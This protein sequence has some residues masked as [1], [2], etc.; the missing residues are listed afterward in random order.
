MKQKSLL[1]S[2]WIPIALIAFLALAPMTTR[3]Q[4]SLPYTQGFENT[5]VNSIPD[6]W[7]VSGSSGN[8]FVAES[9]FGFAPH[10]GS[11][12]L[13]GIGYMVLPQFTQEISNLQLD[14]WLRS[15]EV[16]SGVYANIGYVTD[17][18]N[19][20]GTF[21]SVQHISG[22]S[23]YTWKR[24][25]FYGAPSGAR[26]AIY[27]DTD[28]LFNL[29]CFDDFRVIQQPTKTLPYFEGFESTTIG[30]L[31]DGWLA[32]NY[33]VGETIFNVDP[34]SGTRQ[35]Y[36]TDYVVLP[37]MA[38]ATS[39]LQLDLH[40]RA[41]G[42]ESGVEAEIGY[43]T[44]PNNPSGTF[45]SVRHVTGCSSYSWVRTTFIGAPAGARI[46]IY[47]KIS[48]NPINCWCLDAI[49]VRQLTP[50]AL[51]YEEDFDSTTTGELPTGWL[52]SGN[53]RVYPPY[54]NI[55]PHS[56]YRHL[57]CYGGEYM[58]LP[59]MASNDDLQ[60]DFYLRPAGGEEE[61]YVKIGYVTNPRSPGNNFHEILTINNASDWNA[62]RYQ[63]VH[64][65]TIPSN[66][67]LAIHFYVEG[68]NWWCVDDV[69]VYHPTTPPYLQ[70]FT[71]TFITA[72]WSRCEGTPT[73]NNFVA[74]ASPTPI[75]GGWKW[76]QGNAVF[77]YHAYVDIGQTNKNYWLITPSFYLDDDY[78]LSFNYALTKCSG[79]HIP[80]T[81]GAQ[82]D[83]MFAVFITTNNGDSW[84][85]LCLWDNNNSLF[86]SFDAISNTGDVI[87]FNLSGYTGEMVKFAFYAESG[88]GDA[89]N[90]LHVDNFN[91]V[92]YDPSTPPT[93][94]MGEITG[95]TAK[96]TWTPA[97]DWQ[98]G[99]DVYYDVSGSSL[100]DPNNLPSFFNLEWLN[101]SGRFFH[102]SN[103]TEYTI[104]NLEAYAGYRVWVRHRNANETSDWSQAVYFETASLCVPP[105]NPQV[106]TTQ[107]TATITWEP[108]QANQTSWELYVEGYDMGVELDEPYFAMEDL[109]PGSEFYAQIYGYCTDGDG[110]SDPLIVEFSTDDYD[111]LTVNEGTEYDEFV[112][113]IG[114]ECGEN[115]IYGNSRSQFIIPAEMLT[116]MQYSTIQKISFYS[117]QSGQPWGSGAS[118]QV[119]M[120]E[121]DFFDFDAEGLCGDHFYPWGNY[122]SEFYNG[123]LRIAN[124]KMTIEAASGYGF[125]YTNGNLLIGI[126]QNWVGNNCQV[127]WYGVGTSPIKSAMYEPSGYDPQCVQFLPKTT[128][129]YELDPYKPP[130]DFFAYPTGS[131]EVYFGWTPLEG[132]ASYDIEVSWSPDFDEQ[133]DQLLTNLT[134]TDY[135]WVDYEYLYPSSTYFAHIRSHYVVD[136]TDHVSSW[137]ESFEFETL[138]DCP[139]PTEVTATEIG[140]LTVEL[141][142]T[143]N[144]DATQWVI[145]FKADGEIG[146]RCL[147]AYDHPYAL[148]APYLEPGTT[149]TAR[150]HP[151]CPNGG[152]VFSDPITFT[153]SNNI[154]FADQNVKAL[155]VAN[156][157]TN[158]DNEL[159]YTEAAAVTSLGTVFQGNTNITS[160]NELQYFTGL[161]SINSDAF[162]LCTGLETVTLP[163]TL[164][165]IKSNA[166]RKCNALASI[167]FP[168][169]LTTIGTTAFYECTSLTSIFI[170]ASVTTI[171]ANPFMKNNLEFIFVDPANAVFDSRDNC[172]AIMKKSN[173]QLVV[174][175]KNT[176]IPSTAL[177]IWDHAFRECEGLT[178]IYIPENIHY[179]Y[180]NAF[181]GCTALTSVNIPS[182]VVKIYYCSF[183]DCS[184]LTSI[185]LPSG[186]T[187]IQTL[188]FYGC[189]SLSE[190]TLLSTNP[191]TVGENAF[192]YVD[193]T[194]PVY[195]PCERVGAYH[196]AAG[197]SEFS[198][199]IDPCV[200]NFTDTNVKALC[201]ANWDTSGDGE[202]SYDE[203]A[204]VTDLGTVFQGNTNITSFDELQ[205][206][207][208][209][210]EIGS[211]AFSYCHNLASITLPNSIQ[212][213]NNYAFMYC[214]RLTSVTL[215]EGLQAIYTQVFDYCVRL[216]SITIPASVTSIQNSAFSHCIALENIVVELGN[217]VFD[218]RDG[219]N[220][221]IRT[222]FNQLIIGCKN[223]IIPNTVTSIGW[224]AFRGHSGLT[225]IVLPNSITAIG[226]YAFYD[227][228]GLTNITLPASLESLGMTVFYNSGLTSMTVECETPP[229]IETGSSHSFNGVP[230][231]IPVYVY[232]DYMTDYYDINGTGTWGGF[233]NF[234]AIDC[235]QQ[236][237]VIALHEGWNWWAP[238]GHM[239]LA[240]L[241]DILD[242]NRGLIVLSQDAGFARYEED[243]WQGTLNEFVP[244]KMYKIKANEDCT[245]VVT[246]A[247]VTSV[248][249]VIKEGFNWFGYTGTDGLT[250][251]E[252]LG[253]FV[254]ADGDE[255]HD[256]DGI[257][258][259]SYDGENWSGDLTTLVRG[260][261]YL[262]V[263][264]DSEDK[265]LT[266]E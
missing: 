102:V 256:E 176:V 45:T 58:V 126:K 118:F 152:F 5:A 107:T 103:A 187:E 34:Y 202:L 101:N 95:H 162:Q 229:A 63:S 94:A 174:G 1:K 142:W 33:Y 230:R 117:G 88:T 242:Q 36:G 14:L 27:C 172:N 80:V 97:Y 68:F 85:P 19:P 50:L 193:K 86:P 129:A 51:P 39:T 93:V 183:Q 259:V 233:T 181:C 96:V 200:I 209:L 266:F 127:A 236:S 31:P 214:I 205:Y 130:T 9:V 28:D 203:A 100:P 35:L 155:C 195:V 246:V 239:Y 226:A 40:M 132:A 17:P 115:G 245:I 204:A 46:A 90:R 249:V 244:G 147:T 199:M 54:G 211:S 15:M 113:I 67:Y 140:N 105:Q 12:Q 252:A 215:N 206:F 32:D 73:W 260:K 43:V 106:V 144:G 232:C 219:C 83:E 136:G 13:C 52:C 133:E 158:N 119:Y 44:D 223:T 6:G 112:V 166:F 261:G 253:S 164:T 192:A 10:T 121:V 217:T 247:P 66:A 64:I 41:L 163:N 180:S 196:S 169:S 48:G 160:F 212:H 55:I 110:Q 57:F 237:Q 3:A 257:R 222:E 87:A 228:T 38:A 148:T 7:L 84:I 150:V 213:I 75:N 62:Y 225:S 185:T 201:V 71:N 168:E 122:M 81:P 125:H 241:G 198:N 77:D 72:G 56:G 173:N 197:W 60:L 231:D 165:E 146:E 37:Q 18:N 92:V 4:Q 24:A 154:I 8:L 207:T 116:E 157:D 53:G 263:S 171:D 220:A 161:T 25:S 137:S 78:T 151:M 98:T 141:D 123:T 153:T 175:C 2:L 170:P 138:E 186:V 69:K 26:I 251:A 139:I 182:Q 145:A 131:N 235:P 29:W 243:L 124:G 177:S 30:L 167:E 89:V 216:T 191:P 108:G 156:W 79:S 184:S 70:D 47:T 210:T 208:G 189:S 23:S 42:V 120:K 128:F 149:Y 234:I 104:E 49:Q 190:M 240:D 221:I 248:E 134:G 238:T 178:S 254:P 194:I 76:G 218:S 11:H 21:V 262:Y 114:D 61:L 20:S 109:L 65:G 59:K 143:E 82:P 74:T 250:I 255:I 135:T 22:R 99:W 227:C 258:M 264:H 16:G 179:I 91:L 159:S 224:S 188:A 265:T 111:H